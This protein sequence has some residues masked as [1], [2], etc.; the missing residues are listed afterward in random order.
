MR[1]LLLSGF[2]AIVSVNAMAN[3]NI[4]YSCT[5]D[6]VKRIIEVVYAT[7]D[8]PLPCEV[9]YTKEGQTQV[10]WTYTN[11]VDK[12]E[13]QAASFAGKQSTWGWQ[14]RNDADASPEAGIE[15]ETASK[16]EAAPEPEVTPEAKTGP[17]E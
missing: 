14:C 5:L 9:R 1:K 3:D 13:T 7:P 10:L 6:G 15:P 11:D 16:T 2:A 8:Q 12:C 17:T 4:I